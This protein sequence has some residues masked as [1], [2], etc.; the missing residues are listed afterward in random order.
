AGAARPDREVPLAKRRQ[1]VRQGLERQDDTLAQGEREAETEGRDED[2]ERPL[3]LGRVVAGPEKDE[4][5]GGPRK[6]GR[7]GHQEDAPIVA[8]SRFA[9]SVGGHRGQ[10]KRTTRPTGRARPEGRAYE[11]LHTRRP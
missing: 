5:D 9:W 6:R 11:V 1:E 3:D 7:Q 10:L 8:Q 4:R 2:R